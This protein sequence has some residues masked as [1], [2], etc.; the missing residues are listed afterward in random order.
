MQAVLASLG[1]PLAAM[2]LEERSRNTRE[3]AR[4]SAAVLL[5]QGRARV[6]L[7]TSALHMPRAVALF[8]AQG[9]AV[10]PAA[11]DHTGRSPPGALGWLPDAGAL[12]GSGSALKELVARWAGR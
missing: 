5:P 7:V 3:N 9:F 1:V 2:V 8:E 6:L 12:E 11:T 4:F 10:L